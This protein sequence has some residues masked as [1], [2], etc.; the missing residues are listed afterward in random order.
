M[1]SQHAVAAHCK[2]TASRALTATAPAEGSPPTGFSASGLSPLPPPRAL[3]Q[4]G[5]QPSWGQPAAAAA[6]QKVAAG[7]PENGMKCPWNLSVLIVCFF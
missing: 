5:S 3:P 7:S 1:G 2:P 4:Q 6:C